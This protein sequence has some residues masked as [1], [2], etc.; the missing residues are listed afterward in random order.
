MGHGVRG[1]GQ[2]KKQVLELPDIYRAGLV[3]GR[4]GMWIETSAILEST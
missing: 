1:G 2:E 4:P 3:L